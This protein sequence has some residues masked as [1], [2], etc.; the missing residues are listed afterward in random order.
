[1][2]EALIE[3]AGFDDLGFIFVGSTGKSIMINVSR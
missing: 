3:Y 2:E 1:M